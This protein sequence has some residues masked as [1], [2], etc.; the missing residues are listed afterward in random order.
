MSALGMQVPGGAPNEAQ[1]EQ[2]FKRSARELEASI[3]MQWTESQKLTKELDSRLSRLN[4]IKKREDS[5]TMGS[6][7]RLEVEKQRARIEKEVQQYEREHTTRM[8]ALKDSL[9]ARERLQQDKP[10][11]FERLM[12]AYQQGGIGGAAKAGY[13]MAGGGLGVGM[14]LAGLIASGVMLADPVIRQI[15]AQDRLMASAQGSAIQGLSQPL[16]D[17]YSGNLA[18]SMYFNKERDTAIQRAMQE[19]QTNRNMDQYSPWAGL[20]GKTVGGAGVGAAGGFF[21]GG[22]GA[23]PGAAIGAAT[24]FGKG[25]YDI[26][27]DPHTRDTVLKQISERGGD[28]GAKGGVV[29]WML[30]R[31]AQGLVNATGLA[32]GAKERLESQYASN[33]SERFHQNLE[34]EK[35]KDPLKVLAEQQYRSN[36]GENLHFQRQM[37]MKNEDFYGPGGFLDRGTQAGF[38]RE[39]MMGQG[40]AIMGAGGSTRVANKGAVFANQLARSDI[41]NAANLM[42][43]ISGNLGDMKSTEQA[44]IKILSEGVRLGLDKSDYR[45]EQRKFAELTTSFA[46]STGSTSAA[47]MANQA[48]ELSS[49]FGQTPTLGAMN[50]VAGAQAF[51]SGATSE[52]GTP[53]GAIFAAKAMS[54]PTLGKLD[55]RSLSVLAQMDL[56]QLTPDNPMVQS[57]AAQADVSA[58]TLIA[59]GKKTKLSSITQT[60]TSE[61]SLQKVMAMSEAEFNAPENAGV[62]GRAAIDIGAERSGMIGLKPEQQRQVFRRMR[63]GAGFDTSLAEETKAAGIANPEATTTGR[64]EDTDMA[65]LSKQ[66]EIVNSNFREMSG[67][68]RTAAESVL[69]MTDAAVKMA[70]RLNEIIKKGDQVTTKDVQAAF[71]G[72]YNTPNPQKPGSTKST[73]RSGGQ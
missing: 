30:G 5:L 50:Q 11:G 51:I 41:T 31:T 16:R 22:V 61:A 67:E 26:A 10:K 58:D 6:K 32:A 18:T 17:V 65:A 59:E 19:T 35:D 55:S 24:G 72:N 13:R 34:A 47:G 69:T 2:A 40:M 52:T 28:L 44:T 3:R 12:G 9:D 27:A 68:M 21:A 63:A 54:S 60:K 45:E 46:V 71:T 36:L 39:A 43:Q 4:E 14:G 56:S 38:T 37:G 53:T 62:I 42:G 73:P 29:P 57:M 64:M 1:K 48:K 15:A 70:M 23:I 66:Q 49:Y 8:S 25:I 7:E 33:L 20:V